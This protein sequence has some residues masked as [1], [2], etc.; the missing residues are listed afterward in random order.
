[1]KP[2]TSRERTVD[3]GEK[4]DW[5]G[6]AVSLFFSLAISF[7]TGLVGVAVGTITELFS[8]SEYTV[9]VPVSVLTVLLLFVWKKCND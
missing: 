8:P 7:G 5:E 2:D 3:V 6:I 9:T 1:M 4:L